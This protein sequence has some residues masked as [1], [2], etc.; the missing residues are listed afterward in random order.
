M[1][2][3]YDYNW[4]MIVALGACALFWFVLGAVLLYIGLWWL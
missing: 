4:G 1:R 2:D 3:D